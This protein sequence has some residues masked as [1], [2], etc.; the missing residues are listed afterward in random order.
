MPVHLVAK[1]R[2]DDMNS[3]VLWP[4]DESREERI[5]LLTGIVQLISAALKSSGGMDHCVPNFMKSERGVIAYCS[6]EPY[7]LI[8]EGD[9]ENETGQALQTVINN[10]DSS[11]HDFGKLEREVEKR[12]KELERLWS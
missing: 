8:C 2:L 6:M 3:E 10:P 11:G 12:G 9:T 1:V 7:L 4:T 5:A